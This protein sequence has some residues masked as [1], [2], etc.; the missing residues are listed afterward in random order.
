MGVHR[1]FYNSGQQT[2]FYELVACVINTMG[3]YWNTAINSCV[4]VL[5]VAVFTL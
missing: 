3:H 5:F 2:V 4:Y 1:E